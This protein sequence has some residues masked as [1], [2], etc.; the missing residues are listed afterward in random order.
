MLVRIMYGREQVFTGE[1]WIDREWACEECTID[2]INANLNA[3]NG[4]ESF[5]NHHRVGRLCGECLEE[6]ED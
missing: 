3:K 6:R 1:Q 5:V 2:R 4:D